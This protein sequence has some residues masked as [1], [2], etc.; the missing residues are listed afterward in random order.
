MQWCVCNIGDKSTNVLGQCRQTQCNNGNN[1]NKTNNNG[2]K[3]NNNGNNGNK[4]NNNGNNGQTNHTI[5]TRTRMVQSRNWINP[6]I[7]DH[8]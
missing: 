5:G 7:V 2:N 1:R 4:P 6:R 3:T 8:N